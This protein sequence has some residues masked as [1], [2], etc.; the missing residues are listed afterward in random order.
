MLLNVLCVS[1]LSICNSLTFQDS[2]TIKGNRFVLS[3]A[4]KDQFI[5]VLMK[6]IIYE[7]E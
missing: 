2:E 4:R 1:I 6:G 5:P 7:E 3:L